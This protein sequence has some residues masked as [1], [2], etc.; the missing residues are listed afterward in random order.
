MHAQI[1]TSNVVKAVLELNSNQLH[2]R[3]RTGQFPRAEFSRANLSGWRIETVREWLREYGTQHVQE[4]F[5]RLVAC[6]A[7]DKEIF[8]PS[9]HPVGAQRR[10]PTPGQCEFLR[11]LA[12]YPEGRSRTQIIEMLY[13]IV[14]PVTRNQCNSYLQR[15]REWDE[16]VPTWTARAC[17][18][19][20]EKGLQA[21]RAADTLTAQMR[22]TEPKEG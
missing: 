14:T 13:G 7:V 4:D 11:K 16:V 17:Y 10:V 19:V 12:Q 1:V 5:E 8:M 22:S 21:L 2:Y 6:G 15:L 9:P 20:S 18:R 3:Q